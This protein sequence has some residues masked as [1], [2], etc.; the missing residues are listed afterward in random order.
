MPHD[1]AHHA[2]PDGDRRVALAVGVNIVL[3]VAQV[4]G[5]LLSGSLAL[6]ADALHN[7]SDALS[8]IIALVARRIARRPAD[9]Q[10]TFGYGRAEVVA[11]LVNLTT[12]I[13]LG[14]FLIYEG[15]GRLFDPQPIDGW[16]VVILAAIALVVD[17]VTAFLTYAMA[18]GSMNIRAAFLHN[19][20]DALGSVGVI[21]AGTLVLLYDWR[22]VD[23]IVTLAIAAYILWHGVAE[24]GPAIRLLMLGTPPEVETGAV[25][26]AIDGVGGVARISHL[27]LWQIDEGETSVEARVVLIAGSDPVATARA[28]KAELHDRFGIAHAT[29]EPQQD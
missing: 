23:P 25:R 19:L 16:I 15:I 17:L 22:L 11:A 14:L 18:K 29:V 20:A 27:H 26:E 24:I 6:I 13:V 9:D 10:M 8:L 5:G 21:V 1:H 7:L 4:V 3:T 12:L 28:V 2:G